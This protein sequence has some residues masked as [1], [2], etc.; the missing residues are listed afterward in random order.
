[1][2]AESI[3][4]ISYQY[5]QFSTREDGAKAVCTC[6]GTGGKT[7]YIYFYEGTETLNAANKTGKNYYVYYR[8]SDMSNIIDMLRNEKPIFLL[9]VSEGTNNTRISTTSEAVGEGEQP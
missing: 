5:Y 9:Y 8:Y 4:I 6:A 2:P 7:I 3:E 1:M